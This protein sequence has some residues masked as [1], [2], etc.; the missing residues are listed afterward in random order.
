M[1]ELELC[2]SSSSSGSQ[3]QRLYFE[4]LIEDKNG[5]NVFL[6]FVEPLLSLFYFILILKKYTK[7][8]FHHGIYNSVLEAIQIHKKKSKYVIILLTKLT[9]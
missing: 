6:L 5:I 4:D 2:F 7:W 8:L 9:N 1:K 3:I